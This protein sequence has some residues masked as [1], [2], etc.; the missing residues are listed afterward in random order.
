MTHLLPQRPEALAEV[1]P[2]TSES[3]ND[4]RDYNGDGLVNG[5]DIQGYV[6]YH[7]NTGSSPEELE[8]FISR[9]LLG[10]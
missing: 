8:A 1:T 4:C 10:G 2:T 6:D 9:C 3:S 5:E 7:R